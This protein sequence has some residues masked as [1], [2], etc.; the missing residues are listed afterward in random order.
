MGFARSARALLF[1]QAAWLSLIALSDPPSAAERVALVVGNGGYA[2]ENTTPLDNPV[3]DARLIARTLET[4]GFR[5][6]L[7]TDVDRAA[8]VEEISEFGER[9]EGAGSDAVGL[10]YYAGHGVEARGHNYLIPIGARVEREQHLKTAAVNAELVLSWM[11]EAGNGLNIVVLDACRNNPYGE[12]NRGG[13][14]GLAPMDA[15]SGSV[16]AYAAAPGKVAKDG[17]GENSPYTAA[18]ARA[19]VQPGLRIEDVFKQVRGTVAELT[20]GEQTPW[21]NTSLFGDFY[22]VPPDA[23]ETGATGTEQG[24]SDERMATERLAVDRLFWESVKDSTDPADFEAYLGAFSDGIF[25]SLAR[26]RLRQFAIEV[27]SDEDKEPTVPDGSDAA[28]WHAVLQLGHAAS[29]NSVAYSP[30]GRTIA[31]GSWDRTVRIWDAESGREIR[32]FEGHADWVGS[33]VFSP[34]GRTIASASGDNT[35]RIW[36]AGSGRVLRVLEGHARDVDSV[37]FSPD[38]RT[39]ASASDDNTVRIWDAGSGREIR[40]LEGHQNRVSSVVFSPDGKTIAS[41]SSDDTVR[42]WDVENGREIRVLGEHTTGIASVAYSPDGRTV[43][44]SSEDNTVRIWDAA[45]GTERLMI[46][47]FTD[48][49]W[50]VRSSRGELEISEGAARHVN[51]V[52]GLEVIS[53]EQFDDPRMWSELVSE[54]LAGDPD[55]KVA[56]A[57]AGLGL[58]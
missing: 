20:G 11:E 22:F 52:R 9:L 40:V 47:G 43:A 27:G 42:L 41:G 55:G 1:T 2:A 56:A 5:V 7:V 8:M 54:A 38:G 12:R 30:D 26:I 39:I 15:P 53:S 51:L 48:N 37:A 17:D 44:S 18:L 58:K 24:G 14:R 31:S 57:A 33:V 35:V 45:N 6:R 3:S 32:V 46:V 28:E 16:I 50:I 25:A 29:V 4:V 34:D 13:A 23:T 21:E 49:T 10:F 19:L 36:D